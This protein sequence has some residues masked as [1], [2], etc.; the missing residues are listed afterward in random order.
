MEIESCFTMLPLQ[1]IA[2]AV[3]NSV[4][5]QLID[6]ECSDGSIPDEIEFE[7]PPVPLQ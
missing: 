6:N 1:Q 4:G 5:M 7:M 3:Q 2:G